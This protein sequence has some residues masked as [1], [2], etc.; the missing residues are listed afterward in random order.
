MKRLIALDHEEF[1]ALC[2]L[3]DAASI[4]VPSYQTLPLPTGLYYVFDTDASEQIEKIILLGARAGL[5]SP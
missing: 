3:T 2:E 1:T 4:Y 5:V